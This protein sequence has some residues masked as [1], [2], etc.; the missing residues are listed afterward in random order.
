MNKHPACLSALA[1]L[2]LT[3]ALVAAPLQFPHQ[4]LKFS[5][6]VTNYELVCPSGEVVKVA[7]SA[8]A[9]PLNA[10][11]RYTVT[12]TSDTDGDHSYSLLTLG[13]QS[14]THDT[15]IVAAPTGPGGAA[16]AQINDTAANTF[17]DPANGLLVPAT[18]FTDPGAGAPATNRT[19][20][21]D[22]VWFLV[23]KGKTCTLTIEPQPDYVWTTVWAT[24]TAPAE[25]HGVTTPN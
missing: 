25:G 18:G 11:M 2:A 17:I 14:V 15:K 13:V 16:F 4:H 22:K 6:A 19:V 21:A 24:N 8:V 10:L 23:F 5:S 1:G 12:I 7:K 20:N 3:A 9:P